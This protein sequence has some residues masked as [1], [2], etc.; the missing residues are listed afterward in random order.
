M[1]CVYAMLYA[2]AGWSIRANMPSLAIGAFL[3]VS[4]ASPAPKHFDIAFLCERCEVRRRTQAI[5][6]RYRSLK[7]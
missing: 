6:V 5:F 2:F 3:S 4:A 1:C 7:C